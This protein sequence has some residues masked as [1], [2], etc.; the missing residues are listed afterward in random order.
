MLPNL[1]RLYPE[2]ID[3]PT[4][5]AV[6]VHVVAGGIACQGCKEQHAVS[7]SGQSHTPVVLEPGVLRRPEVMMPG[8][9]PVLVGVDALPP[10]L[11]SGHFELIT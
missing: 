3:Q 1:A 11:M 5:P 10:W 9:Q 6:L 8:D 7:P 4:M 2:L